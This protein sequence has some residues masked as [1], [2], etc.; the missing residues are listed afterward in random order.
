MVFTPGLG[1]PKGFQVKLLLK[2]SFFQLEHI[3]KLEVCWCL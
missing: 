3:C 2:T 1:F